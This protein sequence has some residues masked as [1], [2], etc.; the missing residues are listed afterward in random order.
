MAVSHA[1][2]GVKDH[3]QVESIVDE[4]IQRLGRIHLEIGNFKNPKSTQLQYWLNE[5][6][7]LDIL[8]RKRSDGARWI[9]V[10]DIPTGKDVRYY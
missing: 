10:G 6:Y 5:A 4:T 3:L 9:Y 2:D 8:T 7:A 1:T